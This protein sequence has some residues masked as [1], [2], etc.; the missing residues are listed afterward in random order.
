MPH[1]A[2]PPSSVKQGERVLFVLFIVAIASFV[3]ISIGFAVMQY[4]GSFN[5]N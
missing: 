4:G 1:M 2:K 3:L 5:G